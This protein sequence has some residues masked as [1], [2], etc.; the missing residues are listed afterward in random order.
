[1]PDKLLRKSY[2][3]PEATQAKIAALAQ[4]WGG[5]TSATETAV[6]VEAVERAHKAEFDRKPRLKP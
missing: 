4:R 5:I 2:R 6:L 1:M 3:I